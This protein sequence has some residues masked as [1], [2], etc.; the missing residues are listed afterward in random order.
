VNLPH[1]SSFIP[2]H[3]R[4]QFCLSDEELAEEQRK[5]VDWF[6]EDVFAP[7]ITA[8]AS[9]VRHNVSRFVCDPER[10]ED[11]AQEC[12][13]ARGM[14]VVYTHG[15]MRQRIRREIS[16]QE[17]ENLLREFYH[18]H[19]VA[20]AGQVQKAIDTFGRCVFVD[21][22]SYQEFSL[23]YE[24]DGDAPRPDVVFGDDPLHTPEWIR[25]EVLRLT[26]ESGYSFGLNR[27]FTGTV[28]PLAFYGDT[29]VSSFMLEIN[30]RTYMNEHTT[31]QHQGMIQITS[32]IGEI[33]R[34]LVDRG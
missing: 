28:V 1:A 5:L 4:N 29:R 10:F 24:L 30:R 23:P 17:R 34:V 11:D 12:M 21:C 6:I 31:A 13:S 8:G 18:P 7:L 3:V 2:A 9:A 14:G 15:T 26:R 22:H 27:P 20:L 33:A 19:Q 32:L 25:E 16:P